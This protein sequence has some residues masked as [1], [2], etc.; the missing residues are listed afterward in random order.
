MSYF[1]SNITYIIYYVVFY[2]TET[3]GRFHF[4]GFLSSCPVY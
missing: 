1:T 4:G 3:K 2:S